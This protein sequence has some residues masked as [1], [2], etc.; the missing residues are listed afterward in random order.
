MTESDVLHAVEDF[1]SEGGVGEVP[2]CFD[3]AAVFVEGVITEPD[4]GN[5]GVELVCWLEEGGVLRVEVRDDVVEE[6][7]EGLRVGVV[8]LDADGCLV[9]AALTNEAADGRGEGFEEVEWVCHEF[10]EGCCGPV[11]WAGG[12]SGDVLDRNEDGRAG[13]ESRIVSFGE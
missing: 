1:V 9:W 11:G 7:V 12:S 3:E 2:S 5:D 8:K 10:D 6:S 4:K 13:A